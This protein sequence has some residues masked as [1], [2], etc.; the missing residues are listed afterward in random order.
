MFSLKCKNVKLLSLIL[1]VGIMS[2]Y[3]YTPEEYKD[4]I[5]S[6]S[7]FEEYQQDFENN[8]Q[9]LLKQ[10]PNY[11]DYTPFDKANFTFDCNTQD[12]VSAEVTTS[13]HKLRPGDVKAVA[14]LG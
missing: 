11:F 9:N 4:F 10:E 2:V 5:I 1:L 14:A 13:V 7:N 12:F 8:L 3:G 6:M